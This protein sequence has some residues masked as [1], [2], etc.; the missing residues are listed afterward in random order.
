MNRRPVDSADDNNLLVITAGVIMMVALVWLLGHEHISWLV[1]H[2]RLWQARLLVFDEVGQR[3]IFTWIA[4]THPRDAT[5]KQLWQSGEI[6]GYHLRWVSLV[7]I[8]A[9]F[10]WMYAR[11]PGR[12]KAFN[13]KFDIRSLARYQLPLFPQLAPVIDLDLINTPLDHPIYGMRRL[14]WKYGREHGIIVR[15]VDVPLDYPPSE[16]SPL[17]GRSVLLRPRAREVFARQLGRPWAGIADP[18]LPRYER[19]LAVAFAVQLG[20]DS[21]KANQIAQTII[22]ELALAAA[23]GLKARDESLITSKTAA[24]QVEQAFA[25]AAVVKVL[26]RHGWRRTVLMGLLQAARANGVL[27]AASFVWLK[28]VDRV[29][30]YSLSDL[31]MQ[32]SCIES[33]GVRAQFQY[34]VALKAPV[35]EPMVES[36]VDAL[37]MYC[38]EVLDDEEDED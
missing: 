20:G 4:Q 1:M 5:L 11:H 9:L 33:A 24:E 34:E 36:A 14:P 3:Q 8:V 23:A 19:D 21:K 35:M 17:D 26:K 37:M 12:Q 25:S 13:R 18:S 28:Q 29:T 7:V 22:N 10:G 15:A 6:V 32:T 27:P 31:G 16:V 2:V 30:W 38:D